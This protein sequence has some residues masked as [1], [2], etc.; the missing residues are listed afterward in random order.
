MTDGGSNQ[1]EMSYL[2]KPTVLLRDVTESK[3]GI[4]ENV[5]MSY[6]KQTIVD[7]VIDNFEKYQVAPKKFSPSPTDIII[8]FLKK[9][10]SEEL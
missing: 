9:I 4:G 3:E 8:D 5:I 2:G 1:Q 6:Y 7:E 10:S